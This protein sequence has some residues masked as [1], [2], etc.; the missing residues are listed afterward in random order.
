MPIPTRKNNEN[1][2]D[3]VSRCMADEVMKKE[4]PDTKQRA[5]VCLSKTKDSKSS[6]AEDV[7]DSLFISNSEYDDEWDEFCTEISI[8]GK[9]YDEDENVIT[10]NENKKV[11]LNKP[12][13]TPGGPKKFSV[14]VKNDK[15]NVVKVNFGDPNMEIKRDNPERRKSFRARHNCSNPGPRW[16]A[17][18]WSCKMWSRNP[19]SASASEEI[20][21]DKN[22]IVS[23]ADK[24]RPGLWENI[25]RKKERMKDRYKPS[26]PGSPD[27]PDKKQWDKLTKADELEEY[28]SELQGMIIGS[29]ESIKFHTEEVLSNLSDA[30]VKENLCEPFLQQVVALA[31]DY[32]ITIHS[33]AMFNKEESY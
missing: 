33:Y 31:E 21:L 22:E 6:F 20:Y 9:V 7:Q 32:V 14:Y 8:S 5:S 26:K 10:A 29:L 19:V 1:K 4:Y 2:N 28:K 11:K 30:S 18:Y 17:K 3:F 13:R 23:E 27:R 25:R 15:G 24:K 12:F 16:K